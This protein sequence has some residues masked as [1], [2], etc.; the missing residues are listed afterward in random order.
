VDRSLVVDLDQCMHVADAAAEAAAV[1][2]RRHLLRCP[3][4][5]PALSTS[6][7]ALEQAREE[8]KEE[9]KQETGAPTGGSATVTG[10]GEDSLLIKEK[11]AVD[12][13]TAVDVAVERLLIERLSAAFPSHK[14]LGEETHG[15]YEQLGPEPTWIIDPIDGTTNFVHGY[16]SIAICIGLAVRGRVELGLVYNPAMGEKFSAVRG[17]GAFLNGHRIR[18][19]TNAKNV[20]QAVINTNVGYGRGPAVVSFMLSNLQTLLQR[21]VRSIRMS[22]SAATSM[23]DVA[24]GRCDAYFE[25]GVHSWDIAAGSVIVEEAGGCCISPNP[26]QS[27]TQ[28]GSQPQSSDATSP[29]NVNVTSVGLDLI[30]RCILCGNSALVGEVYSLLNKDWS[31]SWK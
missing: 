17:R 23:C 6:Q 4:R 16:P 7:Q 21:N 8:A 10:D 14:F 15:G 26:S 13:V 31:S 9:A 19:S 1:L 25:W 29:G 27:H 2:I 5:S 28:S 24:C 12:L 18:I 20:S 3:Y 11:S 22:G 30:A